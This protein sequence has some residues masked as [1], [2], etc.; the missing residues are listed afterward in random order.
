MIARSEQIIHE[1]VHN[2]QLLTFPELTQTKVRYVAINITN[3][4]ISRKVE[5]NIYIGTR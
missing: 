3:L 2:A 1:T 5:T 4:Y